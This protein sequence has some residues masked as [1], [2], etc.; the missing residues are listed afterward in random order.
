MR[1]IT[2]KP[3]IS[4]GSFQGFGISGVS[5][6]NEEWH[7]SSHIQ[8]YNLGHKKACEGVE[9]LPQKVKFKGTLENAVK[10]TETEMQI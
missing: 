9:P 3:E 1:K 8:G 6:K 10:K 7:L 5:V 4:E 2:F